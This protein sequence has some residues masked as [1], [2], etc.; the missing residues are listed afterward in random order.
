MCCD[1]P[2]P[3]TPPDPYVTAN[4]QYGMNADTARLMARLNRFNQVTP[5]GSLTWS[6]T[7]ATT[8]RV[9]DQ[10]GYDEAM[11]QYN[12]GY[13]AA[14]GGNDRYLWNDEQG[15][16]DQGGAGADAA[17]ANAGLTAPNRDD[18]YRDETTES[19]DWTSTVNLSPELQRLYDS[20]LAQ[21]QALAD[22]SSAA[23]QRVSGRLEEPFTL[24]AR[25]FSPW[26]ATQ[27]GQS[28]LNAEQV[29]GDITPARGLRDTLG[30]LVDTA[31]A[32]AAQSLGGSMSFA[33]AP[34][35]PTGD[36]A[37]RQQVVN[38][39]Y[40]QAISRL[41]PQFTQAEDQMRTRLANQGI[42]AG[43]EAYN[44]ETENFGRTANDAYNQAL[45][46]AINRGGE[47][48]QRLFGM[49]MAARQQGV[50]EEQALRDQ[51]LQE[52][53]GTTQTRQALA[54]EIGGLLGEERQRELGAQQIASQL[55]QSQVNNR[56]Q[57]INEL[58]AERNQP[59]N[60]LN[61][62][63][64]GAQVSL[65]TFQGTAPVSVVPTD[66]AGN[67]WNSYN[68]QVANWNAEQASG[69]SFMRGLMGLGGSAL[70][71]SGFWSWLG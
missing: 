17:G 55:T 51:A 52:L 36:A 70:G 50:G 11:R 24:P 8:E 29:A 37:T 3:P 65:P 58:M 62:L 64:S 5:G 71:S 18:F 39:L 23:F 59:L 47:E 9:F 66:L 46:S 57:L 53:A 32:N 14:T 56:A 4:A 60:E 49:G 22:T 41:D 45:Y 30:G 20:D 31:A 69:D 1:S 48:M 33:N 6:R 26:R 25:N 13:G 12:A 15:W 2:S 38:A 28:Q 42:T 61:A 10:T 19:D 34:A 35:M 7:P 21:R 27:Y 40:S 54:G 67:V 16:M 63:R 68:N 43:S 44:R